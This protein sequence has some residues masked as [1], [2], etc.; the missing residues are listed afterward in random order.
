[1]ADFGITDA[2]FTIKGLDII[3][4]DSKSRARAVFPNVDLSDTSALYKILQVAAAEDAELWKRMED[5]YYSNFI[6]TAVGDSLN[7][8]GEDLG[9]TRQQLV[10]QGEVTLT[11][12]SPAPGRQYI[13]SVGLQVITAAPVQTFAT[14]VTVTLSAATPSAT[15]TVVA[16]Q[17]GPA[18][19]LAAGSI[20]GVDPAYQQAYL[21]LGAAT[22]LTAANAQPFSGGT[23]VEADEHY[24]ARLLGLPRSIWTLESVRRAALDVAGVIDVLLSDPLGGV[25]VSQSYFNLLNFGQRPFS[26]D[27]SLGQPY[28]FDVVVAYEPTRSW[29]TPAPTPAN[30]TPVPGVFEQVAAAVEPVRPVGIHPTIVEADH[31]D[32]GVRATIVTERG[33]D[34]Q[35]LLAAVKAAIAADIGTLKLGGDVLFS[36]VMR[37][38]TEQTGVVDVQHMHLRRCPPSFGRITFGAVPFQQAVIELAVGENL[39]MGPTEIAIFRVDSDL[40]DVE[41]VT[42]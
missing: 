9:R 35:A 11:V 5:L 6:S 25:D 36:Q 40:I 34:G 20:V 27:R 12:N 17:R 41:M 4:T 23:A 7:L 29:H 37:A 14:T 10:S 39:S 26:G 3:L 33:H 16:L 2:G 15:V 38:F 24:R 22:T 18:G 30:P 1:M 28:F 42:R 8:L 13:L 19:D 31:I 21:N 32:V